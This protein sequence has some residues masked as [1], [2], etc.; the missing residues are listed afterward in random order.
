M[1]TKEEN[2]ARL[3]VL[4]VQLGREPDISGSAAEISQRVQEW[5]EEAQDAG[6]SLS[7][8]RGDKRGEARTGYVR[9]RANRTLHI[10][11]LDEEADSQPELIIQGQVVRIP[12]DALNKLLEAGLVDGL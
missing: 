5:E 1:A 11:A 10:H 2:V 7:D 12:V 9:V 6:G 4:A 8:T 3:Q